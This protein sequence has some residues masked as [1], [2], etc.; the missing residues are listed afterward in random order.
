KIKKQGEEMT[1]KIKKDQIIGI[2]AILVAVFFFYH[3]QSIRIPENII[4]PGPRM[5]P[6]ISQII[7]AICGVG[8]IIESERKNEKEE[9]Y[10]SKHGWIRL[11]TIFGVIIAYAVGLTYFGFIIVTPFMAFLL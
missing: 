2:G 4:D 10:L 8:M 3:T 11:A 7:M 1:R 5:M 9:E 6:Y